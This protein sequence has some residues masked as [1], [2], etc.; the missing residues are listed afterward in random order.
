MSIK[1]STTRYPERRRN[2]GGGGGGGEC[3]GVGGG[4]GNVC[5]VEIS[6]NFFLLQLL[7]LSDCGTEDGR[8][9]KHLVDTGCV[10]GL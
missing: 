5:F 10:L 4:G 2:L 1:D 9:D 7:V 6:F 3:G 8:I